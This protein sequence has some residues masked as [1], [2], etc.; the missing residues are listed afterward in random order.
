MIV[1]TR[2]YTLSII[3]PAGPQKGGPP[4]QTVY[5]LNSAGIPEPRKIQTGLSDGLYTEVLSGD[6]HEGEAVILQEV[7]AK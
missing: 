4:T 2:R 6:L 3:T 7:K 5:V 1:D